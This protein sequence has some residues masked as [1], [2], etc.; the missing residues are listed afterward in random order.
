MGYWARLLRRET[1]LPTFAE[2]PD[3]PAFAVDEDS[4]PPSVFGLASYSSPVAQAARVDR[5]SALQVPAVK[6]SRDLIATTLGS[7]PVD[8]IGPDRRKVAR[9][10]FDQPE[11]GRA[12][13]VTMAELYA[14]LFFDKHAWW[15]IVEW[16]W[17]GYPKHVQRVDPRAIDVQKDNRVFVT[18]AGHHGSVTEWVPDA[19]LIHFESPNEP[20]LVAGARAI[21][22]ALALDSA[23]QRYAEGAPPIDYFTPADGVDPAEDDEIVDIL[24][25]WQTSRQTRSTGYVP[26]SLKYNIGGWN[27]EQLQLADARQHAVLEIARVAGI[28][29][30]DLGVSTTSRT[31]FNAV[32]RDQQY[33]QRTLRGYA[34]AVEERLSMGD[35]TPRGYVAAVNFTDLLRTDDLTRFQSYEVGLRVGAYEDKNEVREAE[36]KAP[37]S[38]AQQAA[39]LP[40]SEEIPAD[41]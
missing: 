13:S 10:L 20:M 32:D 27:P 4:V 18:R 33:I 7:L 31:Y 5:S 40:A 16:E 22:S 1:P 39:A 29:A 12:R 17:N 37:L 11:K 41:V 15:R 35:V 25:T 3:L 24:N 9:T 26:A 30:E 14:D 2:A 8:L 28:D 21:R 23:A 36:G 6:R 34:S 19:E 38:L